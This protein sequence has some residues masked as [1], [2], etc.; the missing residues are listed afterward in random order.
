MDVSLDDMRVFAEVA[1]AGSFTAAAERLR[2]PKQTV[3]RR[4][5]ALEDALGT[6]LLRRTTRSLK[7]T[8][9]GRVY[10]ERCADL[11]RLADDANRVLAR[12]HAEPRGRLRLTADPNFAAA[13]LEDVLAE[14][15]VRFPEVQVEL[16]VT[17]RQVDLV[18]EGFDVAF[19]VG[20]LDDSAGLIGVRLG[21]ASLVYCA[22]PDYLAGA[23]APRAP[24]DLSAHD[25]IALAPNPGRA[26]WPFAGKRGFVGVPVDPALRT[27][28][29]EIA[30]RWAVDGLGIV[31]LPRYAA[32][33]ALAAGA[34]TTVLDDHTAPAGSVWLVYPKHR[35]VSPAVRALVDLAKAS[36]QGE[37]S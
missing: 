25:V 37:F 27:N 7:L 35:F 2:M 29:L 17:A 14:F 34:L 33:S 11:A 36:L 24:A 8:E 18:E 26:V 12:E 21:P 5:A 28:S 1:A 19:R 16:F 22:S 13:F 3:S 20:L 15:A 30:R 6:S 32:A 31:N 4:V 10:A 23:G 9:A